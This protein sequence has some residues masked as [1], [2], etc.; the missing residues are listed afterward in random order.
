M[1]RRLLVRDWLSSFLL[2]AG[3]LQIPTPGAAQQLPVVTLGVLV[4]GESE[5]SM[6][7]LDMLM[8]DTHRTEAWS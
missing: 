2:V 4:D 1:S 6:A 7:L 3:L 8:P 5:R